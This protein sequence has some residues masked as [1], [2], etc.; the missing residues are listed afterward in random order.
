MSIFLWVTDHDVLKWA[1]PVENCIIQSNVNAAVTCL[2][3]SHWADPKFWNTPN[4]HSSNPLKTLLWFFIHN[5]AALDW[6]QCI[7]FVIADCNATLFQIVWLFWAFLLTV[8]LHPSFRTSFSLSAHLL[9]PSSRL[10]VHILGGGGARL[11]SS[12]GGLSNI[13]WPDGGQRIAR[14]DFCSTWAFPFIYIE[15]FLTQGSWRRRCLLIKSLELGCQ[16]FPSYLK[17]AARF[18]RSCCA[19]VEMV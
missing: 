13:A 3:C 17:C 8:F 15:L 4:N 6:T 19:H 14:R 7:F 2:K 18:S 11:G 9:P 5:C 16:K 12:S 10:H 1:T